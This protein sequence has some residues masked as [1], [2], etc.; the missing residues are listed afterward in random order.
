MQVRSAEREVMANIERIEQVL[1]QITEENLGMGDWARKA[2]CGTTMCFAGHAAV[3]AGESIDWR[4]SEFPDDH[5]GDQYWAARVQSGRFIDE[6]AEEW[7][8]LTPWQAHQ[9]FYEVIIGNDVNALRRHVHK[10]VSQ[11]DTDD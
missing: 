4:L 8:E 2:S 3:L 10:V 9:I 5:G 11:P 1:S 6:V 7:L